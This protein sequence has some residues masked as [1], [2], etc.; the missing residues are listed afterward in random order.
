MPQVI[1]LVYIDRHGPATWQQSM[2][3]IIRHALNS[4]SFTES[5]PPCRPHPRHSQLPLLAWPAA[6][7]AMP[8]ILNVSGSCVR[9]LKTLG[10]RCLR[11]GI[12]EM[13]SITLDQKTLEPYVNHPTELILPYTH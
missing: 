6:S 4:F 11:L 3:I 1:G 12:T 7:Q 5:S 8:I 10:P 13:H 9:K 2:Q